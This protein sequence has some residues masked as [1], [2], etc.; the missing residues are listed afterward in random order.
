MQ[1]GMIKLEN[2]FGV[3]VLR[4]LKSTRKLSSVS[5][6]PFLKPGWLYCLERH[7]GARGISVQDTWLLK[8]YRRFDLQ[9]IWNS[10]QSDLASERS[11][12]R[13]AELAEIKVNRQRPTCVMQRPELKIATLE[14]WLISPLVRV[15]IKIC[16]KHLVLNTNSNINIYNETWISS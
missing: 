15:M 11:A 3:V 16:K 1:W 12:E 5:F 6:I 13:W 14:S 10:R 2:F 8:N 7:L 4:M 9:T